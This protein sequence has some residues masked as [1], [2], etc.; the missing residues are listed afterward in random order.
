V[1][2]PADNSLSNNHGTF[3]QREYRQRQQPAATSH[4]WRQSVCLTPI[5]LTRAVSAIQRLRNIDGK[6]RIAAPHTCN[7]RLI[8]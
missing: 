2:G 1:G 8:D 6:C 7:Q 5:H 3:E 4:A